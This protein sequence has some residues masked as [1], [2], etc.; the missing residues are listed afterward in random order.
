MHSK[1]QWWW[2]GRRCLTCSSA[3]SEG[4]AVVRIHCLQT[5]AHVWPEADHSCCLCLEACVTA[6][7]QRRGHSAPPA[8]RTRSAIHAAQWHA[9]WGHIG[10]VSWFFIGFAYIN[11]C[12]N[13]MWPLYNLYMKTT[14]I[15][16]RFEKVCIRIRMTE[17]GATKLDK[18][19]TV[20][21]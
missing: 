2:A 15:K 16:L 18:I 21:L 10:L 14:N 3:W 19:N 6:A 12:T 11:A 5:E 13:P 9:C 17:S 20:Y 1:P 4:H 7:A 8:G